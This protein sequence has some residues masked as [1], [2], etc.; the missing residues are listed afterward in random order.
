MVLVAVVAVGRHPS[1]AWSHGRYAERQ[2]ALYAVAASCSCSAADAEQLATIWPDEDESFACLCLNVHQW[3]S[4][5][6]QRQLHAICNA[7][8]NSSVSITVIPY[9]RYSEFTNIGVIKNV[10]IKFELSG[11]G[12]NPSYILLPTRSWLLCWVIGGKLN[13]L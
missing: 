5:T 1:L 2:P 9:G 10:K 13:T 6:N 7:T 12:L 3:T 4:L 11:L 8:F